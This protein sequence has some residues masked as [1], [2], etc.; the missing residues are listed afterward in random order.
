MNQSTIDV[1]PLLPGF[2]SHVLTSS[3]YLYRTSCFW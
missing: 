3:G 1:G 2:D